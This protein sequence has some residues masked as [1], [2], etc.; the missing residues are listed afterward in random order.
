MLGLLVLG[1]LAPALA[2]VLGAFGSLALGLLA[3]GSL[4]LGSLALGSLAL[5][6]LAQLPGGLTVQEPYTQCECRSEGLA[7]AKGR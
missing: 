6:S 7:K 2:L 1:S 5:G 4:A 3:L